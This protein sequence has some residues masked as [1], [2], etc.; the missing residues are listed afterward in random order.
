MI[1]FYVYFRYVM[2]TGRVSSWLLKD[3]VIAV[4]KD[5]LRWSFMSLKVVYSFWANCISY[6]YVKMG[7]ARRKGNKRNRPNSNTDSSGLVSSV[8]SEVNGV[9]FNEYGSPSQVFV[10]RDVSHIQPTSTPMSTTQTDTGSRLVQV[11]L[12]FTLSL[13]LFIVVYLPRSIPLGY[14][15]CELYETIE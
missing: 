11:W 1:L 8:I 7:K 6:F 5:I 13:H 9:L 4:K 3:E 2:A 14:W 12:V 10:S 15:N